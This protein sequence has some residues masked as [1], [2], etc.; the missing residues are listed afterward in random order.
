MIA[1]YI[2]IRTEVAGLW[3]LEVIIPNM[4]AGQAWDFITKKAGQ[5]AIPPA[6]LTAMNLLKS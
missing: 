3:G 6:G 1:K 4:L 2:A 5:N